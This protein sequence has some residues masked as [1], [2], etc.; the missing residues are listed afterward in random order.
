MNLFRGFRIDGEMIDEMTTFSNGLGR[1]KAESGKMREEWMK[2][3]KS[4]GE[5]KIGRA[6]V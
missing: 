4:S 6:H 2:V 3:R 1:V 5:R